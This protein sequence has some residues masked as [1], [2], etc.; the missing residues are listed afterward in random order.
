MSTCLALISVHLNGLTIRR[1]SRCRKQKI[2]CSGSRPC[3]ACKKRKLTCEFDERDQKILVTR[4]YSSL[5][6]QLNLPFKLTFSFR[7]L[8]DLQSQIS[9]QKRNDA[10]DYVTPGSL[11]ASLETLRAADPTVSPLQENSI[12]VTTEDPTLDSQ[13]TSSRA[14]SDPVASTLTNPLSTGQS[15]FMAASDGRECELNSC[16]PQRHRCADWSSLP[17]YI[18]QLVIQSSCLEPSARAR[19]SKINITH[20]PS[21]RWSSL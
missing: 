19:L 14:R 9:N 12:V 7:Y 5:A 15:M 4:G 1:C 17:W 20:K 10:A 16:N 8:L 6:V 3:D 13:T 21:F 11:D 2:K 18:L